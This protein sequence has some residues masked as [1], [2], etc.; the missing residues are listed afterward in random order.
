LGVKCQV[1]AF[2]YGATGLV[3][4]E[5]L[6]LL[7]SDSRYSDIHVLARHPPTETGEHERAIYHVADFDDFI[8]SGQMP[9]V[10][11]VFCALGT[12]I[13]TAGSKE[14]FRTVDYTYVHEIA[15]MAKDAGASCFVLVSAV[16]ADPNSIFFYN[17]VKGE[18]EQAVLDLG[19]QSVILVRPSLITGARDQP[20][21]GE[22]LMS[23]LLRAAPGNYRPVAAR[24][25][26]NCMVR[27]ASGPTGVRIIPS[28]EIV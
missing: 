22:R 10:D 6:G 5:C 9:A 4:R 24:D 18:V 14:A 2:I 12:T 7:I 15:R 1:R 17:R 19:F 20:R 28:R 21:L 25:I 16:G 8:S 13:K 23:P 11:H 26:A 27:V 3:G